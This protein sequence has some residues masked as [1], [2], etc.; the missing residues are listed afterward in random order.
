MAKYHTGVKKTRWVYNKK[1]DKQSMIALEKI[2]QPPVVL[3]CFCSKY[4]ETRSLRTVWNEG[5]TAGN[6]GT[7]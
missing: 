6:F 5:L 3:I 4:S 7:I 2:R 1:S